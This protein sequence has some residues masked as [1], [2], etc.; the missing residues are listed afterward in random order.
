[1]FHVYASLRMIPLLTGNALDPTYSM[2]N[3][4]SEVRI[5]SDNIVCLMVL[6]NFSYSSKHYIE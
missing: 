4:I 5:H 1:M 6:P 3:C 2:L